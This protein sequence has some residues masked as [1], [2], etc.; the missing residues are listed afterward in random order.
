MAISIE[1]P[2]DEI[3]R[4]LDLLMSEA[5]NTMLDLPQANYFTQLRCK[6]S[7]RECVDVQ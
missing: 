1:H 2:G 6:L 3:R 7:R 4:F 5:D